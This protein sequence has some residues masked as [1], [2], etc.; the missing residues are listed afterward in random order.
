MEPR[1][2]QSD[3]FGI[4]I[5][6]SLAESQARVLKHGETFAVFDRQGEI[7]PLGFEHHGIYRE[8]TRHLSRLLL[9]IEGKRPLLLSSTIKHDN[10]LFVVDATN[11]DFTDE[12]GAKVRGDTVHLFQSVFLW[13]DRCYGRIKIEN[14]GLEEVHFTLTIDFDADFADIFEVRGH[15]R[16][17][18]GKM[19]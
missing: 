11:P 9:R 8:E 5:N 3:D 16:A 7:R 6:S 1:S 17:K 4:L 14:F 19:Q 13:Q 10:D 15:P 12:K 18:R 2:Q